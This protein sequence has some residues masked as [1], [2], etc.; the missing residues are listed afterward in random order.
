MRLIPYCSDQDLQIPREP[1]VMKKY[2]VISINTAQL[3]HLFNHSHPRTI[4]HPLARLHP[5]YTYESI[6]TYE[7][8][9]RQKKE[10]N[11]LARTRTL[12]N[13]AK[14]AHIVNEL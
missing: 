6:S 9:I 13:L 11:S 1:L 14:D 7:F 12:N 8:F 3:L 10:R 5:L 2:N 4:I